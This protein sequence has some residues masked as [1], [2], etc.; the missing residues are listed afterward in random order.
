MDVPVETDK[1]NTDGKSRICR[2]WPLAFAV[3]LRK[4]VFRRAMVQ[5]QESDS[6]W[7]FQR[8]LDYG[9][10][11]PATPFCS[12][13]DVRSWSLCFPNHSDWKWLHVTTVFDS[14][15][16]LAWQFQGSRIPHNMRAHCGIIH[17]FIF[18]NIYTYKLWVEQTPRSLISMGVD[19]PLSGAIRLAAHCPRDIWIEFSF[20][21]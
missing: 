3:L 11:E 2:I 9:Q 10:S 12:T 8:W 4:E 17:C 1:G 13:K 15:V 20:N 18:I 7:R 16:C 19:V 6:F 5:K 21:K 14:V